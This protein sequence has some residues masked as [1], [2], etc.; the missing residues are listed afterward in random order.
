M[1]GEYSQIIYLEEVGT[2]RRLQYYPGQR[3]MQSITTIPI[4][5]LNERSEDGE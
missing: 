2:L 4:G 5:Q 3:G 1:G